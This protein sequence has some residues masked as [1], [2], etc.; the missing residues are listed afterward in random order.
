MACWVEYRL[1]YL[2][3]L[4]LFRMMDPVWRS[5]QV[6]VLAS[7][8]SFSYRNEDGP[9][10]RNWVHS[11]H[12]LSPSCMSL[13][14]TSPRVKPLDEVTRGCNPGQ[15][16]TS[17]DS[18]SSHGPVNPW[19]GPPQADNTVPKSLVPC[20]QELALVWQGSNLATVRKEQH[21]SKEP[22]LPRLF[23][24]FGLASCRSHQ[25]TGEETTAVSSK[26][27]P[28]TYKED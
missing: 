17:M 2:A 7:W 22:D 8:R 20:E 25:D 6:A 19:N 18:V 3:G 27:I 11:L 28:S 4:W 24:D 14:T 23:K 12:S 13:V 1:V 26:T 10:Q 15:G 5:V 21:S 16:A 9:R